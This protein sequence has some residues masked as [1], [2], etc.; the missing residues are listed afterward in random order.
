MKEAEN[1]FHLITDQYA[2]LAPSPNT[3]WAT[4]AITNT[5]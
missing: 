1:A 5:E 3:L 4:V 2:N